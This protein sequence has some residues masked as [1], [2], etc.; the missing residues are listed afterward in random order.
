MSIRYVTLNGQTHEISTE[1]L[2]G[3]GEW[4][5]DIS[6]EVINGGHHFNVQAYGALGD[7]ETDDTAAIQAA[8]DACKNGIVYFPKGT[9]R[10][11]S[12]LVHGAETSGAA[13]DNLWLVGESQSTTL[14]WDAAFTGTCITF[15]APVA[16]K[17]H[18]C[19]IS[20]LTIY[21]QANA[22]KLIKTRRVIGFTVSDCYLQGTGTSSTGTGLYLEYG[23]AVGDYSADI[24]VLRNTF[25]G[26][27]FGVGGSYYD[28]VSANVVLAVV[29]AE[30][31][32]VG[33]NVAGSIGVDVPTNGGWAIVNNTDFEVWDKGI[34]AGG[35]CV[36]S[37]NRFE[38]N[39]TWDIDVSNNAFGKVNIGQNELS[40]VGINLPASNVSFSRTNVQGSLVHDRITG[41]VDYFASGID[42]HGPQRN[43]FNANISGMALV[44]ENI[45]RTADTNTFS[46]VTSTP[47]YNLGS[48]L[49][50]KVG[51]TAAKELSLY[52]N[53]LERVRLTSDGV[54]ATTNSP[55]NIRAFGA[56]GDGT[57]DDTTAIQAAITAAGVT[58]GIVLVPTGTYRL[59]TGLAITGDRVS[60]IGQGRSSVLKW[61]AAFSGTLIDISATTGN[62]RYNNAVKDLY[63]WGQN[64][65]NVAISLTRTY[66]T[67]IH[68]VYFRGVTV[69]FL[70]TA[71]A[72]NFGSGGD[73]G[74]GA[75]IS[76]C[77]FFGW[78]YGIKGD[79]VRF[80]ACS[81]TDNFLGGP[82]IAGSVAIDMGG[83]GG[84]TIS[85]NRLIEGWQKGILAW[86]NET[87]VGNRFEA[88]TLYDIDFQTGARKTTV[89][90]N[91]QTQGITSYH[92]ADAEKTY[93]TILGPSD[94]PSFI[95]HTLQRFASTANSGPI[96][97]WYNQNEAGG[98]LG[99]IKL[100]MSESTT[101]LFGE[102]ITSR[103]WNF[104]GE[105][106]PVKVGT[107]GSYSLWL[108]TNG[109]KRLEVTGAGA[110]GIGGSPVASAKLEVDSTTQGFLPPV[111]TTTQKNAIS[112]PAEGLVVYDSSLHKLCVY[113]GGG[114]E[115]VTSA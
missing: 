15:D 61:D 53:N 107:V 76:Y 32:I 114:W 49:T 79:S 47:E 57:T 34:V 83:A 96:D 28:G 87:I 55:F 50:T 59:T 40:S 112:S 72:L 65:S 60:L 56:K 25:S 103:E 42:G 29:I 64:A 73:F 6:Q 113:T 99:Q 38:G 74:T 109:A 86:G 78:K 7:G 85:N 17:R 10:L 105:N 75:S 14:Q 30:N 58:G 16:T 104:E 66:E 36:I 44:G 101:N 35:N 63:I 95:G 80:T 62:L 13:Y 3:L 9:Y 1:S 68:N 22:N 24:K 97:Q 41:T 106:T 71:I 90:G 2:R 18:G 37:G 5:W 33:N 110:V 39:I 77:T 102:A 11:T 23:T 108:M 115:T 19:G 91:V 8:I 48:T 100:F 27:K 93:N 43:I 12:G 21:G 20:N 4:G 31:F 88:Q 45:W 94:Q 81:I 89:A 70:G 92:I 82:G 52:T 51:T 26:N 54:L 98:V 67:E 69:G 46:E 111:M 84:H